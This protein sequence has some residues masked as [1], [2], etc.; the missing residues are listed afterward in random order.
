MSSSSS[1]DRE[2]LTLREAPS[3]VLL[4]EAP[5][6]RP[7]APPPPSPRPLPPPP[8]PPKA[9]TSEEEDQEEGDAEGAAPAAP[10]WRWCG[11]RTPMQESQ[12]ER[13]N[14]ALTNF[15]NRRREGQGAY[16]ANM[17]MMPAT[18]IMLLECSDKHLDPLRKMALGDFRPK[19]DGSPA[20]SGRHTGSA[21][22]APAAGQSAAP[23]AL[24]EERAAAAATRGAEDEP[25]TD[26]TRVWAS[27]PIIHRNAVVVRATLARSVNTLA[28]WSGPEAKHPSRLLAVRVCWKQRMAGQETHDLCVGHLHNKTA[29]KDNNNRQQFF[30]ALAMYCAS[31]T[32]IVGLDA[33]MATWG[34]TQQLADRGVEATLVACHWE[35]SPEN[36]PLFDTLG[37]WAIGPIDRER[38]KIVTP[39][40]HAIAGAHHPVLL[41]GR[42]MK[43][44]HRGYS[45]EHHRFPVPAYLASANLTDLLDT[46]DDIRTAKENVSVEEL[47]R[48]AGCEAPAGVRRSPPQAVHAFR[49]QITRGPPRGL[50]VPAE[51]HPN[52]FFATAGFPAVPPVQEI[53][54]ESDEWDPWGGTVGP[55]RALAA[56]RLHRPPPLPQRGNEA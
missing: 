7:E 13:F 22:A 49:V 1:S 11:P 44:I 21:P 14:V 23:A 39:E 47:P 41:D 29:R 10:R 52:G 2:P 12:R 51:R 31:G 20:S 38:C 50:A 56:H 33:N 6:D 43:N 25:L 46:I 3:R 18:I 19:G 34:V 27:T 32:R 9:E 40:C 37:I 42:D 45:P 54:A 24:P 55:G 53:L 8:P 15:G 48:V 17:A 16:D 30:D 36:E 26:A 35:L 28:S 4:R 5:H